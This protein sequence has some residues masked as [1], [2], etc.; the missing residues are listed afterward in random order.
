VGSN[1]T[2]SATRDVVTFARIKTQFRCQ[3]RQC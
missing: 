1:P 2:P 3:P